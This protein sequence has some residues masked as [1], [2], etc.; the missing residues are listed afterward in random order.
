VILISYSISFLQIKAA[1]RTEETPWVPPTPHDEMHAGMS[2]FHSMM[3]KGIPKFLHRVDTAPM[4]T[5]IKKR[6][7]YD[8][9]IQFPYLMVGDHNGN[10]IYHILVAT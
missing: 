2:H 10:D 6:V 3:G 9:S 8:Q 5:V 4:S 1:F 7:P